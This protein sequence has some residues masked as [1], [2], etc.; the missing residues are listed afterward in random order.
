[1]EVPSVERAR[2]AVDLDEKAR[3]NRASPL[4]TYRGERER[5]RKEA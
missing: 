2:S 4:L 3:M 1:M 5:R